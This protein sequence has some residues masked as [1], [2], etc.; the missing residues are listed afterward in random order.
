MKKIVFMG[1]KE[2]GKRCFCILLNKCNKKGHKISGVVTRETRLDG[3]GKSIREICS[4]EE[5]PI[6]ESSV[7]YLSL[8]EVDVVVSV[9]H[10]EI[11]GKREIEKPEQIAINLHMAPLPE[12]RGCNQFSFAILDN[13]DKFGT[14][15]H[16]IDEDV[17][18][19]D[20]LFEDRFTI[21]EDVWVYDLYRK[22]VDRSVKLFKDNIVDIINGNYEKT[23]QEKLIEDRGV[24]KHFRNEIEEIK[25]V[26]LGW[27][28]E[29][30]KRHIRATSMPGFDPPHTYVDGNKVDLRASFFVE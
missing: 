21:S 18:S 20:I 24:S 28:E 16:T 11:L 5:I 27:S 3:E 26:D 17:D 7:D 23:P 14:T 13:A 4:D 6:F 15:I 2:V 30:I 25:R 19:G 8:D 22:T 29:K 1:A 12:Y 10:D 9:Q